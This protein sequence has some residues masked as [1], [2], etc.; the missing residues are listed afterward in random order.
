M[1][2]PVFMSDNLL[3][4]YY[5]TGEETPIKATFLYHFFGFHGFYWPQN[6]Y[7]YNYIGSHWDAIQTFNDR[8]LAEALVKIKKIGLSFTPDIDRYREQ[9]WNSANF[10]RTDSKER[11]LYKIS[12]GYG[13]S[14]HFYLFANPCL[15]LWKERY[16]EQGLDINHIDLII[17]T[18]RI[19]A[20]YRIIRRSNS[21]FSAYLDIGGPSSLSEMDQAL[22]NPFLHNG[23][24]IDTIL[25][26][27]YHTGSLLSGT[28]FGLPVGEKNMVVLGLN[29]KYIIEYVPIRDYYNHM[30]DSF[31]LSQSNRAVLAIAVEHFV[32][33]FI[34]RFGAYCSYN[35]REDSRQRAGNG[36]WILMYKNRTD[37][38]DCAYNIGFGWLP[39]DR[40]EVDWRIQKPGMYY[41][42]FF[43]WAFDI[44]YHF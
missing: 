43:D 23:S 14:E 44:K 41:Y 24:F 30:I 11:Y 10:H 21:F 27:F 38:L 9:Y 26:P 17:P 20:L 28:A 15:G 31:L 33:K 7:C 40:L 25:L 36:K 8:I 39:I 6:S 35:Y 3:G 4:F 5:K 32:N 42:Y 1:Y 29:E 16:V 18:G 22:I 19:S 12:I 13:L 2:N 34:I 37:A